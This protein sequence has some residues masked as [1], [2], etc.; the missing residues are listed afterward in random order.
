MFQ[1]KKSIEINCGEQQSDN[2]KKEKET[3]NWNL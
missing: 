1:K 3:D 2:Q